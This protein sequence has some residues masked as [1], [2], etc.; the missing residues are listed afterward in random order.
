MLVSFGDVIG[1][2]LFFFYFEFVLLCFEQNRQVQAVMEQG[3]PL[4]Q[5][6]KKYF[7]YDFLVSITYFCFEIKE[8]NK[9]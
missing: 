5:F 3:C 4:T 7:Y 2:E 1:A 9:R 6:Y 8:K